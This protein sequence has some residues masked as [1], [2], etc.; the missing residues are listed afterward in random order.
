MVNFDDKGE[1]HLVV[2]DC[3]I[4][5]QSKS[6]DEHKKLV[7]ICFAFMQHDG[8]LAGK[9]MIQNNKNSTLQ[10]IE[11]F[12]NAVQKLITD[13]E[14]H[15][16]F[17]HLGEYISKLCDLSRI[18][19]VRLDPGYFAIAMALKVVEGVSLALNKDLDMVSKCVPIILQTRTLRALGISKFP[20]PEDF[21]S[22]VE[23]DIEMKKK[24]MNH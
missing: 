6:E 4:V 3:G 8:R 23:T 5:Y 12:C 21:D 2:L 22:V 18:Y 20:I 7:D 11:D 10:N 17:E 13:S 16:Y 9:L 1:P 14:E 15:A 24:K 19:S